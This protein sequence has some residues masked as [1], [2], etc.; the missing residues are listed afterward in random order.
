MLAL[1]LT[2]GG[3]LLFG[4]MTSSSQGIWSPRKPGRFNVGLRAVYGASEAQYRDCPLLGNDDQR[5]RVKLREAPI[6]DLKRAANI[7]SQ[8]IQVRAEEAI[9]IAKA[10]EVE[11]GDAPLRLFD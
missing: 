4:D 11:P 3:Y 10:T 9:E 5:R 7:M 2:S 1:S 8:E 6:Y